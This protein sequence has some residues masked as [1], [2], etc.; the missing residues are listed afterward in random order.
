MAATQPAPSSVPGNRTAGR[1]AGKWKTPQG[2]AASQEQNAA[3]DEPSASHDAGSRVRH[4]LIARHLRT[5]KLRENCP[6]CAGSRYAPHGQAHGHHA[7]RGECSIQ[8]R[9]SLSVSA[10]FA[11]HLCSKLF[12]PCRTRRRLRRRSRLRGQRGEESTQ[13]TPTSPDR[14]P[15]RALGGLKSCLPP[16]GS[17]AGRRRSLL[18]RRWDMPV[19]FKLP[20]PCMAARSLPVHQ[21]SNGCLAPRTSAAVLRPPSMRARSRQPESHRPG[22]MRRQVVHPTTRH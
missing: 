8:A 4:L 22:T 15:L 9:D 7:G 20:D 10:G 21:N 2:K 11:P 19:A 12:P 1:S 17:R 5:S 6:Y 13:R 18:G 14:A 16:R 3:A